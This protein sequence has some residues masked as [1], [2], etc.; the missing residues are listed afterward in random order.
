MAYCIN[1]GNQLPKG[2]KFCSNCG[3]PVNQQETTN[4]RTTY[5]D[6]EIHKCPSCGNVLQSFEHKC[7]SCGYELRAAKTTSNVNELAEV[8]ANVMPPIPR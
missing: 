5:Y 7:K 4:K 2:A 8:L 6:G 1:C 3:S